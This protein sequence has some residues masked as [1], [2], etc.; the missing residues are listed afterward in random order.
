VGRDAGSFGVALLLAAAVVALETAGSWF[1]LG[2]RQP[3]VVL[4]YLLGIVLLAV[5]M[6][7]FASLLAT[8]LS[9]AAFDFFF[10]A[11]VFSFRVSD[12]RL[13][14][15]FVLMALVA[16]VISNQ[17]ENIRRREAHTAMLYDM[18]REFAV[19]ASVEEVIAAA[20]R[21][22]SQVFACEARIFLTSGAPETELL[23]TAQATGDVREL[24]SSKG[25][26]G[27]LAIRPLR[28]VST[29]LRPGPRRAVSGAGRDLFELFVSQIAIALERARMADESQRAQLE[30]KTERLRNALLSSVSHDLRT[31]LG[32]IKGAVTALIDGGANV[33]PARQRESLDTI[34]AEATR[35][36]R[37]LRNLLDVT[38]LEAGTVRVRKEWLPVEEAIGVALNR[39]EEQL[40]GR[41][42]HVQIDP[43]AAIAPYDEALVEQV[44]VNLV[45]NATKYTPASAPIEIGVRRDGDL[46]EVQVADRGKGVPEGEL[47]TIFEKF[48]RAAS[49]GTGMG[50]GLTI[51]R[52]IVAA[53]GGS[54]SCRN[55]DGG[56]AVFQFTLP[57]GGE[58]PAMEAL[59]EVTA[60]ET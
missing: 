34:S 51:C 3:D 56:G 10:T 11:P 20:T 35:L 8:V 17:T 57:L 2:G 28:Q 41:P 27:L 31:P 26:I 9:V 59:P 42:V 46:V 39:L 12:K 43:E 45:E 15:T 30:V 52:G 38:S 32:V 7:Y 60:A 18:T 49:G 21:H 16:A 58:P 47:E 22:V 44:L 48:H 24:R 36:N 13:V 6:G 33:P 23:A 54:I 5:R 14:L 50:L 53:H 29:T 4:L 55:R 19:A 25:V 37:L 1:F 40:E